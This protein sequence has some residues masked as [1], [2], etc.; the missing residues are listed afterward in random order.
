MGIAS[1][2]IN[3]VV[4]FTESCGMNIVALEVAPS[5]SDTKNVIGARMNCRHFMKDSQMKL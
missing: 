1:Y 2:Y 3:K 5:T 4:E